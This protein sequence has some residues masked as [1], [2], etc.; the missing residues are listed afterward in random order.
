MADLGDRLSC[1]SLYECRSFLGFS[2]FCGQVKLELMMHLFTINCL[3]QMYQ[4]ACGSL[5]IR[6]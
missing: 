5:G 6:R 3:A 4:L 1:L 2:I